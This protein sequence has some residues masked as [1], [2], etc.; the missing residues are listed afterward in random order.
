P[1]RRRGAAGGPRVAR[2]VDAEG[3]TDR[4]VALIRRADVAVVRA[5]RARRLHRVVRTGG[6][7]AGT[8]LGVVA[9]VGRRPARGARVA[10]IVHAQGATDR[11]VALIRRADVAVVGA[12]RARCLHGVVRTG[13]ARAGTEL[14]IVAVVGRRAT[15]GAGVAR[16]VH[17]ERIAR[18]AVA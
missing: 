9:F 17:A 1:A 8:E 14:G 6:A 10:R 11:A 5:R 18:R 13:R 2:V 12:R 4:A 7:R 15:R 16:V 3:A